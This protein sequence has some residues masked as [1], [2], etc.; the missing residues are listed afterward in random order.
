MEDLL[1][2]IDDCLTATGKFI[3]YLLK[4]VVFFFLILILL[5]LMASFVNRIAALYIPRVSG[6]ETAASRLEFDPSLNGLAEYINTSIKPGMSQEEV[7]QILGKIG[8]IK[9]DRG[10]MDD[11]EHRAC[12]NT[13]LTI[14]DEIPGLGYV[15]GTTLEMTACYDTKGGLNRL[16]SDYSPAGDPRIYVSAP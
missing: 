3:G 5:C 12:D 1:L 6:L 7:E 16:Y 9:V 4:K 2:A 8:P 14:P 13:T 10:E 15:S 11:S